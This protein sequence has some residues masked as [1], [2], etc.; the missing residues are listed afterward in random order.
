MHETPGGRRQLDG[1]D[2]ACESAA[3]P[4]ASSAEIWDAEWLS[5]WKAHHDN[6]WFTYEAGVY[7][8]QLGATDP[9][10]ALRALKTDAF[11]EACGRET[12][13]AA[14]GPRL[15][16]ADVSPRIAR[17]ASDALGGRV[18]VCAADVRTLPFPASTFDVVLSTS[19]L[20]HF[21]E[22]GEITVALT[23]L[24]RVLRPDGRLFVTLDNPANPLLRLR[25]LVYACT[26][27][28]GGL[29]PFRMGLTLSRRGLVDAAIASG[30]EVYQSGYVIH[31]PRVLGLWAGEWVA[32]HGSKR[33]ARGVEAMLVAFER[34]ARRL[35][36]RRW[37]AHFIY[38]DCRPAVRG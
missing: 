13:R 21:D 31:A 32:R 36:T 29:I 6:P 4:A 25:E 15:V 22:R 17:H 18:P 23:E 30:L 37:T 14:L 1:T 34:T 8:D 28:L 2:G 11:D 35:P 12:L 38:A 19:T 16:F 7:V 27:A 24:A 5:A 9:R 26:G 10:R 20:D 3:R 33:G